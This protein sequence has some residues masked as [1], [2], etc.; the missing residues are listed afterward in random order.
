MSRLACSITP[1]E[2]CGFSS[3][4]EQLTDRSDVRAGARSSA[5]AWARTGA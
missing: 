5:S 2:T 1:M 3:L 4:I